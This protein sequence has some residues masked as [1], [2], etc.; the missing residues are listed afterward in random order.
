MKKTKNADKI[1]VPIFENND[2]YIVW[3]WDNIND[4]GLAQ[5]LEEVSYTKMNLRFAGK[6]LTDIEAAYAFLS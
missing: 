5:Y 3:L 2:D 4:A 6:T 1:A